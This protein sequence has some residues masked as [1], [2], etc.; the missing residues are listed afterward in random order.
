MCCHAMADFVSETRSPVACKN[1][2]LGNICHARNRDT[3]RFLTT[4][5]M[6]KKEE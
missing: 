5:R 4:K 6:K 1:T 3:N 2:Y